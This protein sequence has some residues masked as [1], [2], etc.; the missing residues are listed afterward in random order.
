MFALDCM[1]VFVASLAVFLGFFFA[2]EAFNFFYFDLDGVPKKKR[3]VVY[4]IR[5]FLAVY[6]SYHFLHTIIPIG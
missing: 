6:F 2:R 3:M 5:A 4:L 1:D